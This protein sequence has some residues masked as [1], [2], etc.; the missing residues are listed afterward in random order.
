MI[1]YQPSGRRIHRHA[2]ATEDELPQNA[3]RKLGAE[4][5][6]TPDERVINRHPIRC[7]SGEETGDGVSEMFSDTGWMIQPSTFPEAGHPR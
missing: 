7:M 5:N 2:T 1:K 3:I 6:L 4:T